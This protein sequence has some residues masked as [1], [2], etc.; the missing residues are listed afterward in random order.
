MSV[1]EDNSNQDAKEEVVESPQL[2][3]NTISD[4]Q[5]DNLSD[6]ELDNLIDSVDVDNVSDNTPQVNE[7]PSGGSEEVINKVTEQEPQPP[8]DDEPY[9]PEGFDQE[10]FNKIP[11]EYQEIFN[12]IKANGTE[13]Q[14]TPQEMVKLIQLGS[15]YYAD[16][17]TIKP[18]L[19]LV[20]MLE[21]A[22][23]QDKDKLTLALDIVNGDKNALTK[24]LQDNEIDP[25][26]LDDEDVKYQPDTSKYYDPDSIKLEEIETQLKQSKNYDF[27]ID[28]VSNLDEKSKDAFMSEPD[29][30]IALNQHIESGFYQQVVDQINRSKMLGQLGNESFIESYERIGNSLYESMQNQQQPVVQEPQQKVVNQQIQTKPTPIPNSLSSRPEGNAR[31]PQVI[32]LND[33][34]FINSLSSEELEKLLG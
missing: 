1:N 5:V 31:E 13:I 34:K 23:V 33:E 14:P 10:T 4:E 3:V 26:D 20:K 12:P 16:R 32:D 21:K 7:E 29:K 18:Q 22:G 27:I 15:S 17:Q 24:F 2:N 11:K 30:L 9:I 25:M 6:E 8:K 19:E 28:T